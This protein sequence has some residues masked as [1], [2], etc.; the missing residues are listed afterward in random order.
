MET[1]VF[2]EKK[3]SVSAKE[4]N[5]VKQFSIDDIVLKKAITLVENK[6]SEDGFVLP[7]SITLLSR[8]MGY[9]E[10]ARFTGDT[11]YYVKLRCTVLYPVDGAR[12][13]GQV[14][15]KNKMGLY[16]QHR[17]AVHIQVP[18]DLHIGDQQ[19]DEVE[20]GDTIIVELKRSKFTINDAFILSSGAFISK[21]QNGAP[22]VAPKAEAELEEKEAAP[23]PE[24]A[25]LAPEEAPEEVA[26]APEEVSE[27]VAPAPE[28]VPE[29]VV[30]APEEVAPAP[31]APPA[32]IAPVRKIK[33]LKPN[34]VK[35]TPAPAVNP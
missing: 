4:L 10:T 33:S 15:R 25:A 7:G 28:E 29:E 11:N 5:T 23:A 14:I 1:T 30:A 20:I 3:I 32:P 12:V 18:R 24:E 35:A 6:C 9:F 19:Y 31:V 13:S 8:S 2:L 22:K 27:E 17:N 16:V 34:T 26:P 21:E